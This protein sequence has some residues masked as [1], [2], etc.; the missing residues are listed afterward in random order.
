MLH[1]WEGIHDNFKNV[2]REPVLQRKEESPEAAGKA[3]YFETLNPK[4]NSI[5]QRNSTR[6]LGH[7]CLVSMDRFK[8]KSI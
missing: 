3:Q 2:Q 4:K 7:S 6:C 5:F 1:P 8:K